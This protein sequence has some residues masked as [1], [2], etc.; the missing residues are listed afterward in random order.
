MLRTR[1][2]EN[3]QQTFQSKKMPDTRKI[4]LP[5]QNATK[6]LNQTTQQKID[7]RTIQRR[8]TPDTPEKHIQRQNHIQP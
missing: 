7:R 5:Q 3:C 6:N 2:R 1:Q 4:S 8:G